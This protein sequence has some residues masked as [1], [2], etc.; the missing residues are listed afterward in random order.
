LPLSL[1]GHRY[2]SIDD[3]DGRRRDHRI[4]DVRDDELAQ[5]RAP[6]WRR[7]EP[8]WRSPVGRAPLRAALGTHGPR[9]R[10]STPRSARGP[11][12][13]APLLRHDPPGCHGSMYSRAHTN[14]GHGNA[15]WPRAR[16]WPARDR[17]IAL[18][19]VGHDQRRLP[20]SRHL[21]EVASGWK[22]GSAA[23]ARPGP[24]DELDQLLVS[25]RAAVGAAAARAH[26]APCVRPSHCLGG[27]APIQRAA[28]GG[29]LVGWVPGAARR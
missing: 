3:R 22:T 17:R 10:R 1:L 8:S 26:I 23:T 15:P 13:T 12:D 16:P 28:G 7:S 2:W 6:P 19:T 14:A 11:V 29:R 4:I 5:R 24:L 21:A 25:A 18:T 27:A 9:W 20:P